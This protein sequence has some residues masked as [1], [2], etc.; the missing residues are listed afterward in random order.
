M[1]KISVILP[2][3]NTEKYLKQC[4]DSIVNQT[5]QEIEVIC[6]DDGSTDSS[7]NILKAYAAKDERIIIIEQKNKGAG[8]ARNAGIG[9]AKG[10]YLSFL[11]SD[12][13]F[14]LTMLEKAYKI[15]SRDRTDFCVYRAKRFNDQSKRYESI[16][17]T[18]KGSYL[19]RS[20]PFGSQDINKHV[21][22]IFN[23]W[24][25]DKLYSKV[26][27]V[28]NGLKFQ[29][30]RT[31]NDAYFVFM[32]NMLAKKISVLDEILAYHRVNA[33]TSLSVTRE[34]SWDCCYKA[35]MAIKA[36]MLERQIYEEF[37]QS[38]INWALH[39][40][41]WNAR[42]LTGEAKTELIEALKA[43]YFDELE[44][45]DKQQEYFYDLNEYKNYVDICKFGV[46]ANIDEN[47]LLKAFRFYKSCGMKA[48]VK[49]TIESILN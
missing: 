15:C 8:A 10:E 29:E 24:A 38:Y 45:T 28:N 32:A 35:M 7:L 4:L 39:F 46:K 48:T 11:D 12:D 14:D 37:K 47:I 41:L 2:V 3:Y 9:I 40:C 44:I 30:I 31:T 34:K 26:F 36:E 18:I 42:T 49:K 21:F 13:F 27:I 33:G 17:W 19:P 16:D 25:W 23:G 1:I 6:V 22:Q 5:L 20:S 43:N